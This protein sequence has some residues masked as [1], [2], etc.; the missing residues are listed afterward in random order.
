MPGEGIKENGAKGKRVRGKRAKGENEES[1]NVGPQKSSPPFEKRR[2]GG[3][4][5]PIFQK[6][7]SIKKRNT[8]AL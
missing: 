5:G 6:T 1:F 8:L 4:S 2:T 7:K 3:I